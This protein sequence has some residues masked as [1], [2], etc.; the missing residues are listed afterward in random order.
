MDLMSVW[1]AFSARMPHRKL[2]AQFMQ[3]P[4]PLLKL[5]CG[6][7]SLD[8]HKF[9]PEINM[10]F[11]DALAILLENQDVDSKTEALR[12]MHEHN[13]VMSAVLTTAGKAFADWARACETRACDATS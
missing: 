9:V 6:Q 7:P 12:M 4:N 11:T 5:L 1:A 3:C 13:C 10:R 2:L 8:L